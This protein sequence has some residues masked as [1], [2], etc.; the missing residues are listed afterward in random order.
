MIYSVLVVTV[1]LTLQAA[2]GLD[3]AGANHIQTASSREA[4]ILLAEQR[5][6]KRIYEDELRKHEDEEARRRAREQAQRAGAS[7]ETHDNSLPATGAINF[8]KQY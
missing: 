5:D 6:D 3:N 1:G 4:Q 2:I 8:L 7:S